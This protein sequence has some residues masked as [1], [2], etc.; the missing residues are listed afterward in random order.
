MTAAMLRVSMTVRL[1]LLLGNQQF[2]EQ[3]GLAPESKSDRD[4]QRRCRS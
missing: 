3:Y 4:G 1:R 2:A